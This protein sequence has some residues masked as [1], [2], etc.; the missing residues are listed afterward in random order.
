MAL[1]GPDDPSHAL[2]FLPLGS[3]DRKASRNLQ[4]RSSSGIHRA[5]VWRMSD[6]KSRCSTPSTFTLRLLWRRLQCLQKPRAELGAL[7]HPTCCIALIG[8]GDLPK[9]T[10]LWE[11]RGAERQSEAPAQW[12]L[13]CPVLVSG[14]QVPS[15]QICFPLR[16]CLAAHG[17]PGCHGGDSFW[18]PDCRAFSLKDSLAL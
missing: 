2:R 8:A 18:V 10:P 17:C 13:C 4:D 15:E 7:K 11:E 5:Q 3:D 12:G 14:F 1:V 9:G 6:T 16:N